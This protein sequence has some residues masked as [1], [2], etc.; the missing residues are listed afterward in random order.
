M[1]VITTTI[2]YD[3]DYYDNM[4]VITTTILNNDNYVT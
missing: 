2:Q 1:T 4:T 3:G